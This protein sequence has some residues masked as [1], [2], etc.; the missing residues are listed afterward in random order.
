MEYGDQPERVIAAM[1][2][3]AASMMNDPALAPNILEPLEV[4]GLDAFG[5]SQIKIRAR[6]KTVPLKQWEIGRE[7][8][9][10]IY[11]TMR[12]RNI[13][14]PY[15]QLTVHLEGRPQDP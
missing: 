6:I 3:A 11:L 13:A 7:L 15:P 1:K 5:D 2:D 9:R 4:A 10:R 12:E 8:R 14:I